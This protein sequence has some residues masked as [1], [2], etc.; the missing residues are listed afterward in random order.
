MHE[1]FQQA[2]VHQFLVVSN[3]LLESNERVLLVSHTLDSEFS[4][5]TTLTSGPSLPGSTN[6][7]R[8]PGF[9]LRSGGL[10]GLGSRCGCGDCSSSSD[11]SRGRRRAACH[12]TLE[13]STVFA[14]EVLPSLTHALLCSWSKVTTGAL[15]ELSDKPLE[16]LLFGNRL[17]KN[18]SDSAQVVLTEER[19]ALASTGSV[20]IMTVSLDF[21]HDTRDR[22]V[23]R[24]CV[25]QTS[26]QQLGNLPALHAGLGPP[27]DQIHNWARNGRRAFDTG[28]R[29]R[30][31]SAIPQRR[32]VWHS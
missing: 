26:S 22:T 24:S 18:L 12:I 28:A 23:G 19:A 31:S 6:C 29:G 11:R 16:R 15:R 30:R 13:Q 21:I 10:C 14:L 1:R 27:G 20:F 32:C 5:G 9:L 4:S 17:F 2:S 7:T 3:P 25:T 8:N